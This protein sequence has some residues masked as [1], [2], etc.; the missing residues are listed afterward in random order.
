MATGALVCAQL[1]WSCYVPAEFWN[2][3]FD[4]KSNAARL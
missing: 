1:A 2:S 4:L 3:V